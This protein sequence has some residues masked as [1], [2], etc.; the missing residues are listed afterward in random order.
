MRQRDDAYDFMLLGLEYR[1]I[2]TKFL[3]ANG[4]KYPVDNSLLAND[5]GKFLF[6]KIDKIHEELDATDID[7]N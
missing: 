4:T 5:I 1:S 3:V 7:P 6:L 2:K